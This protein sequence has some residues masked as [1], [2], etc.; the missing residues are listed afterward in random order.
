M[1]DRTLTPHDRSQEVAAEGVVAAA[2]RQSAPD[3][4]EPPVLLVEDLVKHWRERVVLDGLGVSLDRGTTVWVSGQNGAGKTTLLR[5][6]SGLI[7]PSSGRVT[8]NGLSRDNGRVAYQRQIGFLPAGDT[9]LYARLSVRRNLE[10]WAGVAFVHPSRRRE[11]VETALERFSVVELASR[12]VDRLSLGQRQRVRLAMTF[13]HEPK[14]ILLDEPA[15]S[16]DEEGVRLLLNALAE[17]TGRGGAA[18]LC[19]PSRHDEL[20]FDRAYVLDA[21]RLEPA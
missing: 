12:R 4:E 1:M 15:G 20:S 14:L 11:S 6:V 10:F 5:I 17:H 18:I 7:S 19:A 9:G 21:G 2:E 13:L 16:L 3:A 8:V